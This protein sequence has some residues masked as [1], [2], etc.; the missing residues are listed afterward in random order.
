MPVTNS[1]VARLFARYAT[2][3]EIEGAN[4]FRV[5]AYRNA[6]RVIQGL[7]R[8]V[9]DMLGEGEDL[10]QLEGIG[11]DLADKIREIVHTGRFGKLDEIEKRMPAALVELTTLPGLGP[12]RVKILY[13]KLKIRT[14][15]DLERAARAG[16]IR[17]IHGFGP[18][19]E[20]KVLHA[21]AR[22]RGR[23]PR[24]GW[25]EA[26]QVAEPLVRALRA[27][28]GV[29]AVVVAGSF[30]RCQET[31]GDLDILAT[32]ADSARAMQRFVDYEGVAD[33]IASG[34][35][36]ATIRLRNGLQV[37]LRVVPE[38]S[39]GAALQYFTGSKAHNIAL[40]ARAAK[41]GLK[42]SEYGLFKGQARV[43]GRT[44]QE[45][46]QRLKLP[47][48]EPELR[49]DHGE[50]T[51]A[52]KREL[53]KLVTL[54]DLHGDLHCHTNATDGRDTIE[55]MAR[56]AEE[57]GYEYLAISD[58]TRRLRIANGL[59]PKRL[60][61]QLARIDRL[62]EKLG[63][64]RVLK[65]AEVDIL[66][67]GSLDLPDDILRDLDVVVCAVH[68]KLELSRERQTER[69]IRAMDNRHFNIL[70]HPSGRLLGER[71]AY[72]VDI[73]RLM[74]AA[75]ARGCFLE[76][77][78]QPQRLD[79]T[80]SDC[81][82]AKNMGLKVAISTDSHS[83]AQLANM[84]LGVAQARRGWLEAADVLNARALPELTKLLKRG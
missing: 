56:G 11:E 43:A 84:R 1:D 80:D 40:R 53:P 45:I 36:R 22:R 9:A 18:K 74:A 75:L 39:S 71:E 83:K 63:K 23:E 41:Q 28:P 42:L 59:D 6:A 10:T 15:E 19:T 60:A 79:L 47:Y 13:D 30:R 37:D 2:L 17:E 3:L 5:R 8:S 54:G 65:S 57:L 32:C 31:V 46:Y 24:L 12:K 44:E 68:Y 49:E 64:L 27:V 82:M 51:A 4:P 25:V 50:I 48:I 58:H 34:T 78:A 61:R 69:I 38:A 62:N 77:N 70:A 67:D 66:E 35:T 72:A 76:V 20:E 26:E 7:P 52:E 16:R 81:R 33:V 21:I 14:L 29:K 73:E 55:T